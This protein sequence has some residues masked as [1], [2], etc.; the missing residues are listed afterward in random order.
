MIAETAESQQF[1]P[2]CKSGKDRMAART[3]RK[4]RAVPHFAVSERQRMRPTL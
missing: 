4:K 2:L 3:G 1:L